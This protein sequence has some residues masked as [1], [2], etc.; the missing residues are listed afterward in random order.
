MMNFDSEG[1]EFILVYDEGKVLFNMQHEGQI[2]TGNGIIETF[3]TEEAMNKRI[4][5]LDLI[6]PDY[7]RL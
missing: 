4:E 7:E 5:E 2:T 3:D 1:N 6:I